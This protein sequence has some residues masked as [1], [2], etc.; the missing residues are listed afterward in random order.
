MTASADYPLAEPSAHVASGAR[1]GAGTRVWH[2]AHVADD[3]EIG[4]GCTLGTSCYVGSGS[5][6]GDNVKIG[7]HAD[8]FGAQLDDGVMIS[9]QA[10][11]TE[12]R[13]PRAT[14][15]DGQRQGPG[16]WTSTPVIVRRGATIGAGA[17]VAPGVEI[18]P[19]AMVGI[20]AVVLRD[21]P[22]HAL[23][24]GNPARAIGWV[25]RCAATLADRMRCPRCARTYEL[26]ADLL[27]EVQP[28]P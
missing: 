21:V 14:R 18:G 11:L 27:N 26:V 25:C 16:D 1:I 24:L 10:V 13:A 19:Y 6:I 20:G 8:V 12:D 15:P 4:S 2:Q 3:V 23:V 28:G 5:R 22:A 7:N 9:P 17:R